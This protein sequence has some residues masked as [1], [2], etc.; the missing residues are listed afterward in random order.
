ME[1][2]FIPG[3]LRAGCA[4]V[5]SSGT[6]GQS[7]PAAGGAVALQLLRQARGS[8][9]LQ[10]RSHSPCTVP[11]VAVKLSLEYNIMNSP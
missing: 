10:F 2:C 5:W 8:Q 6:N 4:S 9:D 11:I 1:L 3:R 7:S